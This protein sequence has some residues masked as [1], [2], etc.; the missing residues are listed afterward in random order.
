MPVDNAARQAVKRR[1]EKDRVI[2]IR[3]VLKYI[4][5]L[6]IMGPQPSS[7][8]DTWRKRIHDASEEAL[9]RLGAPAATF[10]DG[11]LVAHEQSPVLPPLDFMDPL[12]PSPC[13]VSPIH[14][15]L[16][17][18]TPVCAD[19]VPPLPVTH[20]IPQ[21]VRLCPAELWDLPYDEDLFD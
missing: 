1:R 2:A 19:S 20:P 4:R 11:P 12:L 14:A 10:D 17:P 13:V 5:A 9:W 3:D 7:E 18:P 16:K 6:A 8:V 21:P 15:T